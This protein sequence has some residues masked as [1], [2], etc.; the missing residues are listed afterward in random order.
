MGKEHTKTPTEWIKEKIIIDSID[1][2]WNQTKNWDE[3]WVIAAK[4]KH[5]TRTHTDK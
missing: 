2:N 1:Q 5:N 4:G 3:E